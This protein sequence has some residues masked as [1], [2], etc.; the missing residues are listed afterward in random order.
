M[1]AFVLKW[2]WVFVLKG[3][4]IETINEIKSQQG[5]DIDDQVVDKYSGWNIEKIALNTDAE[6]DKSSGF[7]LQSREILE[8]DAGAALLQSSDVDPRKEILE[9]LS[10]PKGKM[11]NN[12][13]T[14]ISSYMGISIDNVRPNIIKHTL[15][16]LDKTVDSQEIHEEKSAR[17]VKEGKKKQKS[18][19]DVFYTSLITFTLSYICVFIQTSIPSIQSKKTFP[20]CKKSFQGYP[21]TGEEDLSNI[22]YLACV[23]AGIKSSVQPWKTLPKKQDKIAISIKKTI[24]FFILNETEILALIEQKRNYLLLNEDDFIPIELDIKRWIN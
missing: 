3:D 20:G 4:Y 1:R 6:Y 7:K 15:L 21:L 2:A 9:L 18:Y 10:N 13:I 22:E 12:I 14:T 8:M 11:I 23:A 19:E 24:D 5:V 16:A 17:M